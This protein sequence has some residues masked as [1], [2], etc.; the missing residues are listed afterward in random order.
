MIDIY[1]DDKSLNT[2]QK[3]KECYDYF[4]KRNL[5]YESIYELYDTINSK[6]T[7][8]DKDDK[9]SFFKRDGILKKM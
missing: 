8:I 2:E 7:K 4:L 9:N 5:D 3:I 6:K 1:L